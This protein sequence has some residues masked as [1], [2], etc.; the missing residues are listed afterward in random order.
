MFAS[1]AISN[2]HLITYMEAVRGY[3]T[4]RP[5]LDLS[6]VNN[7]QMKKCACNSWLHARNPH[8]T[9]NVFL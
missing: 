5:G 3:V 6:H 9:W 1:E 7:N 2:H 8:T 4:H